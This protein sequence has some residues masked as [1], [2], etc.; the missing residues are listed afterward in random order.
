MYSFK[1]K[2]KYNSS[3]QIIEEWIEKVA[4]INCKQCIPDAFYKGK[5]VCN[6]TSYNVKSTDFCSH[7]KPGEQS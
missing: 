5:N 4:C 2:T 6:F 3:G 7:Y 1:T